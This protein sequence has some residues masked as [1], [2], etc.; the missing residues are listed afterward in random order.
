[1]LHS[2]FSV[3]TQGEDESMVSSLFQS[4]LHSLH[5]QHI[6]TDHLLSDIKGAL[7]SQTKTE[8][9]HDS[10]D[11]KCD[12]EIHSLPESEDSLFP[13][14]ENMSG[15]VQ[16][17]EIVLIEDSTE[18]HDTNVEFGGNLKTAQ[19]Q[20]GSSELEEEQVG[21]GGVLIADEAAEKVKHCAG[22]PV[23]MRDVLA[24]D[25]SRDDQAELQAALRRLEEEE[26]ERK[27]NLLKEQLER[28]VGM[29]KLTACCK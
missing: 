2:V 25:I 16:T 7:K 28:E 6:S 18:T 12:M 17:Q 19:V 4:Y 8:S 14:R 21:E 13:S 11:K 1:M 22:E 26:R 9:S 29:L 15:R 20:E 23:D 5:S 24:A 27:E 10:C 3:F